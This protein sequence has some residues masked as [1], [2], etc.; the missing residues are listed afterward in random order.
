MPTSSS[1]P[2]KRCRKRTC[3]NGRN[4]FSAHPRR[5]MSPTAIRSTKRKI[6]RQFYCARSIRSGGSASR[7]SRSFGSI[8][9]LP[10]TAA[11]SRAFVS[12]HKPDR[13]LRQN[14]WFD[15][16]AGRTSILIFQFGISSFWRYSLVIQ[17]IKWGINEISA[18]YADFTSYSL[19]CQFGTLSSLYNLRSQLV[20]S[21]L[22]C[23]LARRLISPLLFTGCPF[24]FS[25]AKKKMDEKKT[26]AHF[27]FS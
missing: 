7:R 1:P 27:D 26:P 25:T 8:T 17:K 13:F 12:H 22:A 2:K 6:A 11:S 19:R 4:L 20:T 24:S 3:A 5:N 9:T 10:F 21:S 23:G 14:I 16:F 18:G 15:H